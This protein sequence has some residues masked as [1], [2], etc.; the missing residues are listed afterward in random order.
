MDRVERDVGWQ[1]IILGSCA[2]V[3]MSADHHGDRWRIEVEQGVDTF[4]TRCDGHGAPSF[5]QLDFFGVELADADMRRYGLRRREFKFGMN[6]G[7]VHDMECTGEFVL[8][9]FRSS[10]HPKEDLNVKAWVIKGEDFRLTES[11][12]ALKRLIVVGEELMNHLLEVDV[13]RRRGFI[14]SD[15]GKLWKGF[16]R[17]VLLPP[18]FEHSMSKLF[19]IGIHGNTCLV[20]RRVW[21]KE[22]ECSAQG[23]RMSGARN[24]VDGCDCCDARALYFIFLAYFSFFLG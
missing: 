5:E 21:H 23:T 11:R 15:L 10:L 3:V 19:K 14:D 20:Q 16:E 1:V 2:G 9:D 8:M 18:A 17:E 13:L 4:P 22:Q 7:S 12:L 24:K 6:T